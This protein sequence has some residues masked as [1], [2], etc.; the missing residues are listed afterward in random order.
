MSKEPSKSDQARALRERR[1]DQQMARQSAAK[2]MR[3]KP[4]PK[5]VEIVETPIGTVIHETAPVP[6]EVIDRL[7]RER[8]R[9]SPEGR[10]AKAATLQ[11]MAEGVK[12]KAP[13]SQSRAGKK[14]ATIWLMPEE[15][16]RLQRA[17]LNYEVPQERILA[18][19]LA[20]MLG[21]KYKV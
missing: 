13:R 19:G 8:P 16:K 11:A 6:D 20:L 3:P 10:K 2:K 7:V 12:V 15:M 17:S 14:A 18:E 21:D 4:L 9:P 5:A 1:Y